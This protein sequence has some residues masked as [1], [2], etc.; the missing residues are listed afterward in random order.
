MNDLAIRSFGRSIGTTKTLTGIVVF[1]EITPKE[2][3]FKDF[4]KA[5]VISEHA[6]RILELHEMGLHEKRILENGF[7]F[8]PFWHCRLCPFK[9]D[10]QIYALENNTVNETGLGRENTFHP[11]EF[12]VFIR[13]KKNR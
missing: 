9:G 13:V 11:D 10:D 4:E 8:R 12:F 1:T 2:L 5:S 7:R 3:G 6:Q